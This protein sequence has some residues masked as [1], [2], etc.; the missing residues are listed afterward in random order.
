MKK[1]LSFILLLFCI[2]LSHLQAQDEQYVQAN[3]EKKV[4]DIPMR[5]G[6]KLH[7]IVYLPKDKS[8][9][10]PMLMKRTCY[11]IRPY[12]KNKYPKSL[13]P[14]P[15]LMKDGYIF[16]YQDVRGRYMSEGEFTTMTPNIPGNNKK[17]KKEV[18]ESSD[19]YDTIEWLLK[20]LKGRHN[21]KVG[22]WGISYP[23]FY[24]AA[25]LPDA[26][27]ALVASSPQAPIGDFFF[28][29]FHHNGAFLQSY[30]FAYPVFGY[31]KEKKQQYGWYSQH[32]IKTTNKDGYDFNL[33]LGPLKNVDQ[34]YGKDNFFWQ[35]TIN[36]PNYDEFW[37]KRGIVQH[38]KDVDHAV[39]TVGGLFDAED[40][41]GPL[42]IYKAL[43]KN[44]EGNYNILV[45]G[46]WSHGDWAREKGYQ[47]VNH[48]YF[49]DSLSTFYQREIERPFFNH[50]LKGEG[51]LDLPEAY[52]FD[53]GKNQWSKFDAWPAKDVQ[54][55]KLGFAKEGKLLLNDSGKAEDRFEYESDPANPVPY[56]SETE[57]LV[58]TPRA[59]MTDDQRHVANRADVLT[60]QT[61]VLEEDFTLSGEI[62]AKLQVAMT[63]TDADFVVK[64]IDVYPEDHP[65]FEHN[66][67]KV[68]MGGYQMLVRAEVMRGRF[69]E[70][71][72]K[73]IPFKADEKTAVNYRL[74]DIH[75]TFKKGHR[76]MIQIHSTWFP[77][78][79]RNPQKYV[80]NI[81]KANEDDFIK[82]TITIFGDSS[83]EIGKIEE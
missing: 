34:Y 15:L 70:S 51:S 64:I 2:S 12:G 6:I 46:P 52:I 18:D 67:G 19:T 59:Y 31:Q 68:E 79:D 63:G 30:L 80:E 17:N 16:V 55:I 45:M 58:F 40:L 14:N 29:D 37:Q 32:F 36:H 77:Y 82:S 57:G 54:Q 5:D 3:Y 7:T 43:E 38:M 71:F 83:I 61:E 11:S 81:Y 22:Q 44:N 35:E 56:R 60:F 73:P 49:G 24:T 25:S 28:D 42:N 13:G 39:M 9:K 76:L 20:K 26:H 47:A 75:H 66:K 23:G 10:Y 50:F 65:D 62:M 4:F 33:K 78:I 53:T 21:G 48:I 8:K 27:P 74:Q 1:I 69:R 41:Y 72:S